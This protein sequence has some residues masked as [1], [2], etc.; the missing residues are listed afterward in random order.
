MPGQVLDSCPGSCESA[1]DRCW[2]SES[3]E[4][5]RAALRGC[6]CHIHNLL[7]SCAGIPGVERL[8]WKPALTIPFDE[9]SCGVSHSPF[10]SG[11]SYTSAT[12][13][14]WRVQRST[15]ACDGVTLA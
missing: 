1:R 5:G 14:F 6:F 12:R 10:V 9:S 4:L 13:W 3:H 2:I 8:F 11:V 7:K 15:A